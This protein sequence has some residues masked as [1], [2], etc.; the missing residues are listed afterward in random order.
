MAC[1]KGTTPYLVSSSSISGMR[2][3]ASML[4]NEIFKA[5]DGITK[6]LCKVYSIYVDSSS[7]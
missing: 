1:S 2:E 5:R 4:G 7:S 6:V 3:F